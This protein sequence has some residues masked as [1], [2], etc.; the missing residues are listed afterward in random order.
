VGLVPAAEADNEREYGFTLLLMLL[1]L[2]SFDMTWSICKRSDANDDAFRLSHE[3][4][5]GRVT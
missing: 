2:T 3:H 5:A 1:L 4:T